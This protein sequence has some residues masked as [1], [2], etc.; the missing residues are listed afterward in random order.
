MHLQY[1][2]GDEYTTED[3]EDMY[4]SESSESVSSASPRLQASQTVEKDL[5]M[6]KIK[7]YHYQLVT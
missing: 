7:I 4:G 1:F 6:V 2:I 5:I 3:N